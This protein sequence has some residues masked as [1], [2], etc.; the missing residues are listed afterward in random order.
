ML[1]INQHHRWKW[2]S[3][4]HF[5]VLFMVDVDAGVAFILVP[6]GRK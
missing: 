3:S 1:D 4:F 2:M 5:F 6:G